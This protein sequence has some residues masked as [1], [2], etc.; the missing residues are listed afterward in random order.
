MNEK[1]KGK[2]NDFERSKIY[3]LFRKI[4]IAISIILIF[5]VLF[6]GLV[7]SAILF[8]IL[9]IDTKWISWLAFYLLIIH[10]ILGIIFTTQSI[11]TNTNQG[12][13]YLK[14]NRV[15][16]IRRISGILM[17]VLVFLHY[18]SFGGVVNGQ[19][20]LFEFNIPS[21]IIQILLIISLFVHIF[22]N[23]NPMLD[24]LGIIRNKLNPSIFIILWIFLLIFTIAS[25][26]YFISWQVGW[27][28]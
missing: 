16:W 21:L 8:Q 28:G 9:Y 25:I 26:F 3:F 24:S 12:K 17:L 14:Q 23:I 4:N 20:M 22:S 13:W 19:Y 15:F 18:S 11:K 2:I 5:L 1:L 7:G 10:T 6:H 27:I